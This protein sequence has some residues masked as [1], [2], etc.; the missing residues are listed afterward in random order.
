MLRQRR[1]EKEG[2]EEM[3]VFIGDAVPN[4]TN[5]THVFAKEGKSLKG[6]YRK[7]FLFFHK[8]RWA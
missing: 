8:S 5:A 3:E 1:P 4:H 6:G 2:N 7:F